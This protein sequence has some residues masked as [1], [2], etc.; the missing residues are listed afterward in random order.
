MVFETE[1][2]GKGSLY[3]ENFRVTSNYHSI[4]ANDKYLQTIM[5]NSDRMKN[6][7]G[8]PGFYRFVHQIY[9]EGISSC[10]QMFLH[11]RLSISL[12]LTTADCFKFALFTQIK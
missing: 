5:E 12:C 8:V 9:T 1:I 3:W 4:M 6:P 10:F 11:N 7:G 2:M